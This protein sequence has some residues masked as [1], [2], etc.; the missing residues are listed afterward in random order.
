[1]NGNFL[2]FHSVKREGIPSLFDG[3]H[4]KSIFDEPE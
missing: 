1:M 3:K 4:S 2:I